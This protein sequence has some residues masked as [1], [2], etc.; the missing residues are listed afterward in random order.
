MPSSIL[1]HQR[2]SALPDV[3]NVQRLVD[4]Q[5]I[6]KKSFG[7]VFRLTTTCQ[8]QSSTSI[9]KEIKLLR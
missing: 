3:S 9:R 4:E 6:L 2:K 8:N 7:S 1:I 5:M